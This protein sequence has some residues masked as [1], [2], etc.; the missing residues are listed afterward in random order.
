MPHVGLLELHLELLQLF[1]LF[2]DDLI[3]LHDL[4]LERL[5]VLSEL[6]GVGYQLLLKVLK[7]ALVEVHLLEVMLAYLFLV[8]FIQFGKAQGKQITGVVVFH[9]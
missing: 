3:F 9:R 8:L 6:G 7:P 1:V 4:L 2:L 5:D